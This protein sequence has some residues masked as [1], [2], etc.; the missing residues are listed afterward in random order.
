MKPIHD[1]MP[2]ILPPVAWDAWLDP[3]PTNGDADA[4]AKLLVPAP[5]DLLVARPMF[6]A[7]NS[8]RNDGPDLIA[9]AT[10]D[11]LVQ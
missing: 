6:R 10:G 2:V 11:D 1:R 3:D 4:L 7:V 9:K 8:T 5:A